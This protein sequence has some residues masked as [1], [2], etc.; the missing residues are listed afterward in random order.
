MLLQSLNEVIDLDGA[1]WM[2]FQ[3]HVPGTVVY[4]IAVVGLLA[5]VVVGYTFG[6]GGPRQLFSICTLSVAITLVL[7]VIIDLDRP[8][9][10]LIRVSQ[11]PMLDLQRQLHSR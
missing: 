6:L 5:S 10:G 2:A 3:N 7:M 1:R 11:Q 4:V 9:E 8:H